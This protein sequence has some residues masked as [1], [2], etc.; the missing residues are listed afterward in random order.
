MIMDTFIIQ[1]DIKSDGQVCYYLI[2]GNKSVNARSG[3]LVLNALGVIDKYAYDYDGNGLPTKPQYVLKNVKTT[4]EDSSYLGGVSILSFE[5]E[6]EQ[7]GGYRGR[8][9]I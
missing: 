8:H 6:E 1:R 7:A 3:A 9:S 2:Q 5:V 4:P